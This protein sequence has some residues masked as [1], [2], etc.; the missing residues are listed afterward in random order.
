MARQ[1]LYVAK[2]WT[3][4]LVSIFLV[5]FSVRADVSDASFRLQ[6]EQRATG[7]HF[8]VMDGNVTA[9]RAEIFGID[10][11]KIFDSRWV[12]GRTLSWPMVLATG[13]LVANGVYLYTIRVRDREGQER[14]K[15]GKLAIF[16]PREARLSLPRVGQ[17]AGTRPLAIP[18]GVRW[19]VVAGKGLDNFR[20][21]RRPA[22]GEPFENLIQLDADGQL[23][24]SKLCLGASESEPGDCRDAWPELAEGAW[25]TAGSVVSLADSDNQVAIGVSPPCTSAKLHVQAD[26]S[27][28]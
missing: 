16:S 25:T 15:L 17:M 27:G 20:I 13:R 14:R 22:N 11:R 7:F 5:T 26:S 24:I 9:L 10:G 4:L 3:L 2:V 21:L 8:S 12:A 1:D 23:R 6:V 19:Q 28:F 18:L